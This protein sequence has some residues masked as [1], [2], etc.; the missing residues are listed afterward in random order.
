LKLQK[1]LLVHWKFW[2]SE[3][4]RFK[5]IKVKE[6]EKDISDPKNLCASANSLFEV[7]SIS[8][9]VYKEQL[10]SENEMSNSESEISIYGIAEVLNG[11]NYRYTDSF[12]LGHD[13]IR[14]LNQGK[15]N[16]MTLLFTDIV[17]SHEKKKI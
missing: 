5:K 3:K 6:D 2:K 11:L 4:V 1:N 13:S 9:Q 12:Y 16:E 8:L 10:S 17:N 15:L 14:P 7:L